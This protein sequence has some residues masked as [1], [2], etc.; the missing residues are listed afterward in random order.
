MITATVTSLL[1][2][3]CEPLALQW[4]ARERIGLETWRMLE[5]TLLGPLGGL[6]GAKVWHT[7]VVPFLCMRLPVE[8]V[9]MNWEGVIW[10]WTW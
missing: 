10:V 1:V 7:V 6:T 8:V 5:K 2:F 3:S 4:T 9:H